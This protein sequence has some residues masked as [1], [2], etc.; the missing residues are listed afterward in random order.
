M[1][2]SHMFP[3]HMMT[4]IYTKSNKIHTTCAQSAF[5]LHAASVNIQSCC[6]NPIW[7]L[8]TDDTHNWLDAGVNSVTLWSCDVDHRV[9]TARTHH[10]SSLYTCVVKL[11]QSLLNIYS[12]ILMRE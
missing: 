8:L 5:H 9:G 11:R 10:R 3:A 7:L 4:V 12:D 1:V 6:I 2:S